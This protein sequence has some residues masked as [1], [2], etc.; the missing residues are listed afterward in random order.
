MNKYKV[1]LELTLDGEYHDL[2]WL[3][4]AVEDLL[5]EGESLEGRWTKVE[6]DKDE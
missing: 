5:E 6:D 3:F 2:D 1:E 4:Q